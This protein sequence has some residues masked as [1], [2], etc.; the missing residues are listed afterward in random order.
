MQMFC[1]NLAVL[2]ARKQLL[3]VRMR[4]QKVT[5]LPRGPGANPGNWRQIDSA[6]WEYSHHT[7]VRSVLQYVSD[8]QRPSAYTVPKYTYV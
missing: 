7:Q 8:Q 2:W 4:Y 5:L 1:Q 3:A 6:S